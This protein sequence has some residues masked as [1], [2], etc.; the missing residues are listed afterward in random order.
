VLDALADRIAPRLATRLPADG[1]PVAPPPAP[2]PPPEPAWSL[3][4]DYPVSPRPRHGHGRPPHPR[5][6]A[7]FAAGHERFGAQVEALARYHGCFLDIGRD[8][9]VDT[10]QPSWVNGWLP[11]LDAALLYGL[12]ADRAPS[13]Y[14]EVGSG[15]STKFV[16]RA[17][18]DHGLATKIVS[19]HPHPRADIDA[20]C[21]EVIR[22][23][24]EEA[25]L[26]LFGDLQ[27]GD[28]LF[29]DNS[30]RSLQNSDVTVVFLEVLPELAPGVLAGLHDVFLP[31]DYPPQ[32]AD[33]WYSEQ[34]LLASWLLGGAGGAEVHFPAWYVTAYTDLSRPLQPVWDALDVPE[35]HGNAFFVRT[36]PAAPAGGRG[37]T[38]AAGTVC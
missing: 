30:H 20:L 28:V 12:V 38:P 29:V 7:A 10:E 36:G 24:L 25:D 1:A 9:G 35:H 33:R 37:S 3:A 21:D 26:S 23:P 18:R 6:R 16:R 19:I 5:L 14:I 22:R 31:D 4:V 32:W 11:P 8:G 17:V 15:N 13:L 34:Y 27:A 2:S